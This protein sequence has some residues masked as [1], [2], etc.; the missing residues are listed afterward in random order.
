MSEIAVG[1]CQCGCGLATNLA[2][3]TD[4]TKGWVAGRPLRFRLGHNN[5]SPKG[6]KHPG[7][8][9]GKIYGEGRAYLYT[10]GHLRANNRGYVLQSIVWAEKALGKPLPP[11]AKVHHANLDK[12]DENGLVVCQ[13]ESYHQLLHR[14]TR[15]FRACGHAGWLKCYFCQNY[16][17][18]QRMFVR[19]SGHS[20][21]HRSCRNQHLAAQR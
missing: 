16:D 19:E 1:I 15:A 11:G 9:G 10:P 17:D 13:G 5:Y 2:R 4:R 12:V 20:A 14:R 7:W 8:K 6:D 18:P 3:Q 21:Y